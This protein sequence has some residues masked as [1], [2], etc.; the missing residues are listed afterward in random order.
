MQDINTEKRDCELFHDSAEPIDF[1]RD[2]LA[3]LIVLAIIVA[4][5]YDGKV[6]SHP[7]L[8]TSTTI[9]IATLKTL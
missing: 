6:S 7:K 8:F 2:L 3:Y 1:M 9:F 4:V 5:A